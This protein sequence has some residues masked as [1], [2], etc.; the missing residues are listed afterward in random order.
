[1]IR[2]FPICIIYKGDYLWANVVE[3]RLSPSTFHVTFQDERNL[4]VPDEIIIDT[5][6]GKL[7]RAENSPGI[8]EEMLKLVNAEIEEYLRNHPLS[9]DFRI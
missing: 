9:S 4:A 7:E 2:F 1:M 8:D 5:K 3:K 6:N